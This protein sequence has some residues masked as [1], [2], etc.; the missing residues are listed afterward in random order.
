MEAVLEALRSHGYSL[1]FAAVLLDQLGIP[2]PSIPMLLGAGAFVG[3]GSMNP[4]AV[5]GLVM[6]ASLL[7]DLVWYELGRRKGR[8][9]L[10]L[11]CRVSLEP[12]TCVRSTESVFERWGVRCL[13][14]AKFV[15]GLYTIT[16]P[17]AG[18][19]GLSRTRFALWDGGGILIWAS[20][21]LSLGYALRHQLDWLLDTVESYGASVFQLLILV[22]VA[23]LALK[24]IH[25]RQ[26]IGRLRTARISPEDLKAL[27]DEGAEPIIADLRRASDLSFSPWVIPGALAITIEE[28]QNRHQ[29]IPRDR[30]VVLYCT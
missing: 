8:A 5:L 28:L 23:H 3:M 24:W 16:P 7:A 18:M 14:F 21:Y 13:L 12:D 26:F 1:L 9:I 2:L 15:P 6:L 20:A 22:L 25:R 30:E 10:G 11:L 29:E 17:M 27:I 19:I 4:L